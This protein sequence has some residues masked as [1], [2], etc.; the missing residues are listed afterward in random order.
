MGA[1]FDLVVWETAILHLNF[2]TQA[3]DILKAQ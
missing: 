1:Y 3:I 2:F